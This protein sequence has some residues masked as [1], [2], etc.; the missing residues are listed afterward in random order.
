MWPVDIDNGT[1]SSDMH[2]DNN[3]QEL[4]DGGLLM[5]A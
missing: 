5:L 2:K 3:P 4:L 1:I